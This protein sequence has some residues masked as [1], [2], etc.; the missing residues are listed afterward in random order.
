VELAEVLGGELFGEGLVRF[1]PQGPNLSEA[2]TN[3][4]K[5]LEVLKSKI[6]P[7]L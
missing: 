5:Q 1:K 7:S 6:N 2:E 3:T 4:I